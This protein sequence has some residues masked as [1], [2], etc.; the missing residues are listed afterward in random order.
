[1]VSSA[2]GL[3]G[4]LNLTLNLQLQQ[5]SAMPSQIQSAV[6]SNFGQDCHE[7]HSA[8]GDPS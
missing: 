1:M 8:T 5:S 2:G 3:E 4:S 6:T 7:G